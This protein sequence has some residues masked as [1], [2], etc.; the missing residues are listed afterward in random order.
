MY[1]HVLFIYVCMCTY[2]YIYIYIRIHKSIQTVGTQ[3]IHTTAPAVRWEHN[4]YIRNTIAPAVQQARQYNTYAQQ[5]IINILAD[6]R[7]QHLQHKPLTVVHETKL[8]LARSAQPRFE[9]LQTTIFIDLSL[10]LSLCIYIY[11]Y[12]HNVTHCIDKQTLEF[13]RNIAR[14]LC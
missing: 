5:H 8:S 9:R 4:T 10:S 6:I 1:T 12:T 11:I 14:C 7:N 2:I 13:K 3:H